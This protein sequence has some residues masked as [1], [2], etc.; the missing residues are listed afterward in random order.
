MSQSAEFHALYQTMRG[1]LERADLCD[2]LHVAEERAR[3]LREKLA[4]FDAGDAPSK[5]HLKRVARNGNGRVPAPRAYPPASEA[6][7]LAERQRA[8][9]ARVKA[10]MGGSL[11]IA[12]SRGCEREDYLNH[13][14][15]GA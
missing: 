13:I 9:M 2:Q 14:V 5:A 11:T 8:F 10:D 7:Q 4:A 3:A 12:P 1:R 15:S 6:V